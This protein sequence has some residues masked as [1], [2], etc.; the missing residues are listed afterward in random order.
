MREEEDPEFE[1]F[2]ATRDNLHSLSL[3]PED[4]FFSAG[5]RKM[6]ASSLQS[7][8]SRTSNIHFDYNSVNCNPQ[9][10]QGKTSGRGKNG[11]SRSVEQSGNDNVRNSKQP[12]KSRS[13]PFRQGYVDPYLT[14]PD[15]QGH[16]SERWRTSYNRQDERTTY[17]RP[18]FNQSSYPHQYQSRSDHDVQGYVGEHSAREQS[19]RSR[20]PRTNQSSGFGIYRHMKPR[21]FR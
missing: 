12:T 2:P 13:G 8:V 1:D 5:K 18:D 20:D 21:R 16:E 6:P 9:R 15:R 4:G 14:H 10:K 7:K 11:G 17:R 19:A 3:D